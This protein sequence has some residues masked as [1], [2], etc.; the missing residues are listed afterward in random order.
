MPEPLTLTQAVERTYSVQECA[1]GANVTRHQIEGWL[2]RGFIKPEHKPSPPTPRRYSYHDV[3]NI[4]AFAEMVRLGL[5]VAHC[6]GSALFLPGVSAKL[7]ILAFWQGPMELIGSTD[8]QTG[9]PLG[10]KPLKAYNPDQPPIHA[11]I[12]QMAEVSALVLDPDVR[13][14]VLVNLANVEA[15]VLAALALAVA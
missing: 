4:S 7:G 8:R 1:T 5:P 12:V 15:R 13:G 9:K 11:R 3:F 14:L 6:I 10:G 2:T